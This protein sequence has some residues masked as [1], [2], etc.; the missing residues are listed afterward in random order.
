[1]CFGLLAMYVTG[2]W[3]SA[4]WDTAKRTATLK[5]KQIPS[6]VTCKTQG[7]KTWSHFHKSPSCAFKRICTVVPWHIFKSNT[8]S[9]CKRPYPAHLRVDRS[10]RSHFNTVGNV[11]DKF[12]LVILNLMGFP[13]DADLWSSFWTSQTVSERNSSNKTQVTVNLQYKAITAIS[14]AVQLKACTN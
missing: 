5:H 7:K 14:K 12:T 11:L 8:L 13:E 4:S 3:A 6:I 1:M 9:L 2:S 10:I